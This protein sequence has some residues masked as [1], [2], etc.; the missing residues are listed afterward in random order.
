MERILWRFDL[1][2]FE[3]LLARSQNALFSDAYQVFP[4]VFETILHYGSLHLR[5]FGVSRTI[6]P[7]TGSSVIESQEIIALL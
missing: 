6:L 1:P 3:L 4:S 5:L 7:R 2:A